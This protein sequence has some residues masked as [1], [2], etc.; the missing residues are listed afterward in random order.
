M[1]M[2]AGKFVFAVFQYLG[3]WRPKTWTSQ[4]AIQMYRMYSLLITTVLLAFTISTVIYCIRFAEDLDS[5]TESLLIFFVLCGANM[6]IYNILIHRIE[7]IDFD[8][9]FLKKCCNP[10]DPQEV[11]I[12]KEFQYNDRLKL[13]NPKVS[14]L[15]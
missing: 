3:I 9:M 10:R 7:I 4:W 5:L 15:I 8:D 14:S 2:N 1:N 13:L 6:K 12:K 11:A